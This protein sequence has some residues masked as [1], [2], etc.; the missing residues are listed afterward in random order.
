M[1]SCYICL[2][3]AGREEDIFERV[4]I[5]KKEIIELGFEPISPL[6][7]NSIGEEELKDHTRRDITAWYMGRDIETIISKCDCIYCCDGWQYSKGCNVE[8]ECA[9]QYSV[10]IYYQT[11]KDT[12]ENEKFLDVLLNRRL[13]LI[14]AYFDNA[15]KDPNSFLCSQIMT[16]IDAYD[17]MTEKFFG[18]KYNINKL[19]Y[20]KLD[21]K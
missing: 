15:K 20:E 16:L 4:E 17:D 9:K 1:K 2:P 8:I 11:P 12:Y 3:I 6:D 5:A 21:T 14:D 18:L 19:K 13:E 10:E 7:L